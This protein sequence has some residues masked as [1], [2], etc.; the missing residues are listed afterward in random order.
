M[1]TDPAM[2]Q[3]IEVDLF[4]LKWN[5][6]EIEKD[7]PKQ[8]EEIRAIVTNLSAYLK[9]LHAERAEI[10]TDIDKIRREAAEASKHLRI[11]NG[12]ADSVSKLIHFKPRVD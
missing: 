6:D 3:A 8:A 10:D 2:K 1:A 4:T 11:M 12:W 5:A 9:K 7:Y